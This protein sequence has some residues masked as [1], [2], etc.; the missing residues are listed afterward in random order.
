MFLQVKNIS[1]AFGEKKAIDH[2]DFQVEQGRLVCLLGPSGCGKSTIL[3]AIGGFLTLDSGQIILDG[4]EITRKAPEERDISTVFQS[5]GLF[6]HMT[7][8]QNIT[9]GLKFQDYTKNQALD[10]GRE[11]LDTLNLP[12]SYADQNVSQLSGG[13]QQR[14]A[15]GRSLI[16][17]PKLL[18]LDEPLSNL[19]AKLRVSMRE[20]IRRIQKLFNIT[21]IFVT[22]D[23]MEAF[24]I[25][26]QIVLLN[27]GRLMQDGQAQELYDQPAN[28]FVMDF[29]GRSNR[30]TDGYIRPESIRIVEADQGQAAAIEKVVFQGAYLEL[31]LD[32]PEGKLTAMVLNQGQVFHEGETVFIDYEK[33]DFG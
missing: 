3:N 28:P 9:Y 19:D 27:E 4:E 2:V 31:V 5:Y 29:I 21:M 30:L 18:L 14:V 1:K 17:R 10:L 26:D 7:V 20:E 11:M 24:E 8:L 12:L 33:K 23:Q 13:E 32:A 16:V 22:H 15:L 25:A 6:P